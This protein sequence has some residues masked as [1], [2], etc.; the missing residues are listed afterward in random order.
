[1]H[2]TL[3]QA[4]VG[5]VPSLLKDYEKTIL[6][7]HNNLLETCKDLYAVYM[8]IRA[9]GELPA[10]FDEALRAISVD[11]WAAYAWYMICWYVLT[12]LLQYDVLVVQWLPCVRVRSIGQR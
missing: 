11:R 10:H 6:Q 7:R 9:S 5:D 2:R 3:V 12:M 8:E 1:M 4:G